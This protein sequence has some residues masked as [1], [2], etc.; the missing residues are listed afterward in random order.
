MARFENLISVEDLSVDDVLA[1]FDLAREMKEQLESS[2]KMSSHLKGKSIINL[3]Y[4][5]STRTRSS[6]ELAGKYLG[7]EVMNITSDGSSVA[8]GE[9]LIDT[10]RT[11]DRL[12]P[13]IIVMRHPSS[14]AHELI[15]NKIEARLLNAG[16]GTHEHP[17]Q[18]LLDAFTISHYKNFS[19]LK[20]LI[21]GDVLHSRV[22]RSNILLLNKLGAEVIVSGPASLVPEGLSSLGCVVN[23]NFDEAIVDVDVIMMLRIQLERQKMG[24]FPSFE[25]YTRYYCLTEERIL[26]AKVDTIILHPGPINRGLEI[27]PRVADSS[28]ALIEEQ[29]TNGLAI[30]MA[31][32]TMLSEEVE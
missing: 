9:S 28:K 16:D 32:L 5:N 11:L 10:V 1:I 25:E 22:A 23:H 18:A 2:S 7:A 4:E 6:F 8:K 14:G 29:V 26:Q 3:F 15:K 24:L 19:G 30:R 31:L 27:S 13:D 12:K 20:V 17:T 21:V